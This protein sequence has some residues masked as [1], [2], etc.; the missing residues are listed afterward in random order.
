MLNYGPPVAS[1][2]VAASLPDPARAFGLDLADTSPLAAA[3]AE[4]VRQ[5]CVTHTSLSHQFAP[6]F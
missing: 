5:T 4:A 2:P 6:A 1:T 3:D